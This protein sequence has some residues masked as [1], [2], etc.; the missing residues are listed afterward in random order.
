M[1]SLQ[2]YDLTKYAG[3]QQKLELLCRKISS[4]S[5]ALA[6]IVLRQGSLNVD[7]V[8]GNREKAAYGKFLNKFVFQCFPT[9]M[10]PNS[11]FG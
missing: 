3:A 2:C 8:P 6:L 11:E 5:L 4:C 7:F 10:Y 9:L 1:P